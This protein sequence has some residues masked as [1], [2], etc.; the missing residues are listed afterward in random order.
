MSRRCSRAQP[1]GGAAGSAAQ[2]KRGRAVPCLQLLPGH[3]WRC[4]R[5][6]RVSIRLACESLL[7]VLP[8]AMGSTLRLEI[9]RTMQTAVL[10]LG[11]FEGKGFPVDVS[12]TPSSLQIQTPESCETLNLPPEVKLIP[13][14]CRFMQHVAGEGLHIRMKVHTDGATDDV[15][16][17][18][19]ILKVQ[20]NITF[21]CQPCGEM[22]IQEQQFQRVLPLPSENWSSLVEEWCCHPDPFANRNC[23]P[24]VNDCFLGDT[25]L[26]VNRANLSDPPEE[27]NEKSSAPH[28]V[29]ANVSN[30]KENTKVICKRCKTMLG[31]TVS[32]DVVKY[33]ITE[34][35]IRPS[36]QDFQIISRTQFMESVIVQLLMELSASKS[37]YRFCVQGQDGKLYLLLW[38]LNVDTL[39]VESGTRSG[40]VTSL[41]F[42]NFPAPSSGSLEVRNAVRVLFCSCRQQTKKELADKW[43]NETGAQVLTFPSH[44]CLE[45]LLLL[46][47]NN[48]SLPHSLRFMNDWQKFKVASS[49]FFLEQ[50]AELVL[51]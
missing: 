24:K 30:S 35:L 2:C 23:L 38:L 14:S 22:I 33:Y 9:R 34:V 31:E 45:L 8:P 49:P 37:T 41:F 11:G 21:Q 3:T 16:T 48:S 1:A 10:I 7:R 40:T 29:D 4:C 51:L 47:I 46:S 27:T 32:S 18:K 42:G 15:R 12:L 19:D 13:S 5:R 6:Q 20:E 25:F 28:S 17:L 43:I 26:L 50:E 44:T 36:C 39:L